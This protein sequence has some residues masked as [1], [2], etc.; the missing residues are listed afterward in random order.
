MQP[1]AHEAGKNPEV[2]TVLNNLHK[3]G[4]RSVLQW[5]NISFIILSSA[6]LLLVFN[7]FIASAIS[8]S[9]ITTSNYVTCKMHEAVHLRA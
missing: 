3:C 6:Q 4:N 8:L 1:F 7:F 2:Y 5:I 9:V